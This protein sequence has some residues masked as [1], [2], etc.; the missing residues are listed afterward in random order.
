MEKKKKNVNIIIK[1]TTRF[2]LNI[3]KE[4]S[5]FLYKLLKTTKNNMSDFLYSWVSLS[6]RKLFK[7]GERLTEVYAQN[8]I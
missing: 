2:F 6:V 8:K 1:H 5:H 4:K 3:W 7:P